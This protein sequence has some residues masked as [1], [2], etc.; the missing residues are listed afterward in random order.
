MVHLS[1][2]ISDQAINTFSPAANRIL[3]QVIGSH[4]GDTF[5][6]LTVAVVK[7]SEMLLNAG[8]GWLDPDTQMLPVESNTLF[9]LASVSKLF[10][11][12]AFLT[13]VSAGK[14][15]LDDVLAD[16]IPEFAASGPR[17][18]DGG[19]DPHTKEM[20]P[21]LDDVRG[22]TVDPRAVTLRQLV[23]HTSGLAPWRDVFNAA[24]SPP[25]QRDPVSRIE[26]WAKA[27]QALCAYPFV[28][29][30]GEGVVR[31]SDLGLMLLGEAASRLHGTPGNLEAVVEAR[32]CK[33]LALTQITYNPLQQGYARQHIAPTEDDPGWRGRR[34]WGDVHDE[35][36]SGV[37]GV[38]GHAG[39]FG[40]ARDVAALGQAWLDRDARLG[41]NPDLMAS[42]VCEQAETA[43]MRRGLGWL[44][45]SHSDSPAGDLVH[46]DAY[47]HTGFTGTS[48]W[49]DPS[50]QL[51]IAVLTNR[52]Y[53][54]REKPGIH[55]FRRAIHDAIVQIV[56][57]L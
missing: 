30:P 32:V 11:T 46:S 56:D 23:T 7:R 33:P 10:T 24:G 44:L 19:Q 9:D 53:P 40:T 17:S 48:L 55:A 8:W 57:E 45:K 50:R 36:A 21:I 14:I 20:L 22:Q 25:D 34:C 29:Q 15:M 6:A 51:V 37:G 47:G 49:V 3:D 35:N 31:Y 18:M 1:D 42:A 39:V 2:V 27:L 28:G 12:T 13:F 4:L 38:A 54:G 43:G 5:P 52:V 41:I 16:V 26:R